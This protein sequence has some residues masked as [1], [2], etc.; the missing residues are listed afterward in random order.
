MQPG[1]ILSKGGSSSASLEQA[2]FDDL[3]CDRVRTKPAS[4]TSF[5][6][7]K[8]DRSRLEMTASCGDPG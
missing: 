4:G 6:K 5:A 7:V 8:S 1:H 3:S 2:G